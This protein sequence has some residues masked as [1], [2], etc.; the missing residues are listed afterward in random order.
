MVVKKGAEVVRQ[1]KPS[2][3]RALDKQAAKDAEQAD[4]DA[5]SARRVFEFPELE[6]VLPD[7]CVRYREIVT[8]AAALEKERKELSETIMPL[9]EAVEQDSIMGEGWVAVRAHGSRT[10]LS[11]EKLLEA[12][13]A[14]DT[15][16]ACRVRRSYYYLQVRDP[17]KGR[18]PV[19]AQ[20]EGD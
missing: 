14:M 8:E 7:L 6:D 18:R 10:T 9:L 3:K 5:T 4:Y 17:D 20:P 16:E 19:T 15:I 11:E 2:E 12:G 1:M 13:V